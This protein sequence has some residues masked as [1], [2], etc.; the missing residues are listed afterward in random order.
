M[1]V[2]RCCGGTV[3]GRSMRRGGSFALARFAYLPWFA[4]LIDRPRVLFSFV[5]L[6]HIYLLS[7]LLRKTDRDEQSKKGQDGEGAL[8][9]CSC[10]VC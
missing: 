8:D 5:Y 9:H 2:G 3:R 6:I 7:L 10:R 1:R 4:I